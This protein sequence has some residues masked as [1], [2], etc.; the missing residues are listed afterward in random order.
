[1]KLK[2]NGVGIVGGTPVNNT[3]G[4]EIAGLG[5]GPKGEPGVSKK[6]KPMPFKSF[7]SRKPPQEVA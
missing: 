5:V 4:G 6:K 3:G 7:F 1:M 2:E